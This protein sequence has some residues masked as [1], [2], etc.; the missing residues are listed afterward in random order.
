MLDGQGSHAFVTALGER[1]V[2]SPIKVA[3][4]AL[5]RSA[6]AAAERDI[7][8]L[9]D[10][11]PHELRTIEDPVGRKDEA[12]LVVG[13]R[14]RSSLGDAARALSRAERNGAPQLLRKICLKTVCDDRIHP[15][16]ETLADVL[17]PT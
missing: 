17:I 8:R 13:N 11:P 3:R 4:G 2:L 6:L 10:T 1:A 7:A 5:T 15:F 12:A 14:S 16:A 9:R